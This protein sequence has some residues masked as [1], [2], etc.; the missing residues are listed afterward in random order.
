M[1]ARRSSCQ[2]CFQTLPAG[3]TEE[4][5]QQTRAMFKSIQEELARLGG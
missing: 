3:Y 4:R 1:T 2:A 5:W